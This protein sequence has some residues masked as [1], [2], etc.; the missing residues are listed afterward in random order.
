MKREKFQSVVEYFF[1]FFLIFFSQ[2]TLLFGTNSS[3]LAENILYAS[4]PIA[5]ILL[6]VFISLVNKVFSVQRNLFKVAMALCM[7][8]LLTMVVSEHSFS[9]KYGYECLMIIFA[10]L[11]CCFIPFDVFCKKFCQ[12]MIFLATF[13][14]IC[15]C[16]HY[17]IPGIFR[18]FPILTN[19]VNYSFYCLFFT[20]VPLKRAYVT[21]RNYGIFREPSMYQVFL[22]LALLILFSGKVEERKLWPVL[23]LIATIITTF[24]TSGYILCFLI[25]A[26]YLAKKKIKTNSKA[27]LV[28]ISSSVLVVFLFL[29]GAIDFDHSIFKKLFTDNSSSNSRFGA[30]FVDVYIGFENLILGKGFAYTEN[31][32]HSIALSVFNLDAAHNTNTLLKMFAVHG[33]LFFSLYVIGYIR[34]FKILSVNFKWIVNCFVFFL[35][36][37]SADLIFNTIIYVIMFYGYKRNVAYEEKITVGN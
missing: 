33:A 6:C 34:F 27:L 22:N 3:S 28:I 11:L 36:L 5:I 31:N 18:F 32:F 25:I 35:S 21:F 10:F 9:V 24:S 7:L 20:S 1:I 8:S 15:F 16:L 14:L 4:L 37:S 26:N 19:E 29:C 23:I 30:F 12:I 2:D 17:I 13:S